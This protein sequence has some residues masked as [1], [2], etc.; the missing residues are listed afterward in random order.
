MKYGPDGFRA[1]GSIK[2]YGEMMKSLDAGV[3]RVLDALKSAGLEQDTLV[4]FTS[5]NGGERF[6]YNWPFTGK[7]MDLYEGGVRVPAIVRWPGVTPIGKITDQTVITM[8]WTATIVA[9]AGGKPDS[10]YP[11]DGEDI[12]AVLNSKSPLFDRTFFW[13]TRR[14]GAVRSGKWKYLRE[15]RNEFLF[16]LSADE[17]EQADFSGSKPAMVEGLRASFNKW[18]S[19]MQRYAAS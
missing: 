3:G 8:D 16:D 17:R 1:G 5:D 4:I 7:K 10:A 6:S 11:M 13:R 12:T 18:E 15:G 2:V 9:A 19:E 14:Q